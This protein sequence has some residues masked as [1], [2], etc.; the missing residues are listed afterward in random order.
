MLFS[1]SLATDKVLPTYDIFQS[2]TSAEDRDKRYKK[3]KMAVDRA[4]N[5]YESQSWD[6]PVM[7]RK[8]QASAAVRHKNTILH[9]LGQSCT[10]FWIS[11]I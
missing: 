11:D 7:G 2:L 1:V 4:S 3:W 10:W 9:K 6:E 8:K 5:S